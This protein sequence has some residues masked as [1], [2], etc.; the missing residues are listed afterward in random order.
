[1]S[2]SSEYRTLRRNITGP[3]DRIDR[4]ENLMV[5]G[6]PDINF[7]SNGRECWIEQKSPR[8]PK[9]KST[10]LFASNHKVSVDQANWMKRQTTAGGRAFFLI[11]TDLRWLLLPGSLADE[12]NDMTVNQAVAAALWHYEK[13]IRDKEPWEQLRAILQA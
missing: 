8:E 7:C 11:V 3:Y 12:I 9:R 2:E 6:M 1:M 4:I 13:P 5:L 10:K